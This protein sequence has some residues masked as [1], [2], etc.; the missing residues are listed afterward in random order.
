MQI[1]SYRHDH[2]HYQNIVKKNSRLI[3]PN[4]GMQPCI[5]ETY[6]LFWKSRA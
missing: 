5:A 1:L 2:D 4:V 6:A 3:S